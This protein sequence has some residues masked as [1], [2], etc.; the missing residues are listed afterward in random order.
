MHYEF[1]MDKTFSMAIIF[2]KIGEGQ[3]FHLH[4]LGSK[5]EDKGC[6]VD[7]VSSKHVSLQIDTTRNKHLV[8]VFMSF[9]GSFNRH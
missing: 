5:R 8:A 9:H 1:I 6:V 3:S 4:I 7:H 2:G